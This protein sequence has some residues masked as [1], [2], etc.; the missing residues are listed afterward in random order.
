MSFI[1]T[2]HGDIKPEN[3]GVVYSHEHIVCRPPYWVEKSEDDL[4]LDDYEASLKEVM[5]FKRLGGKSIVDATAVDYGRDVENVQH[6]AK[7]SGVNIL[8]TAG[9][10]KSFLWSALLPSRL[11]A[12]IGDYDT[13]ESWIESESVNS[14]TDFVVSEV[15]EGLEGTP[16]KAGQV[17]FGTGYNSITPLEIKTI[18]A[19]A[20]AHHKTGA[21][22]HSHTEAGTMALEQI[23]IL[24]EEGV[25][26]A[27]VSFGHMDRNLDPFYHSQIAKTGAFLSF[28]GI[29]KVKYASESERI[30][31]ILALIDAGYEE[32]I[33]I[34][35]DTARKSYFKHYGHGLGFSNI[36]GNWVPRFKDE[37][38]AKGYD[39]E[40]LIQKFFIDNPKRCFTFKR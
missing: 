28:D 35:G 27:N 14:L 30:R 2:L 32:Q 16:Y 10:N 3:M 39:T 25:D 19:V 38:G 21:P 7:I 11:K 33:L 24:E 29:S 22:I 40:K 6:I 9:F 20:R 31:C 5:D 4:I 18:K 23:S 1:R 15:E 34:S 13:Y 37:A 26:I 8:G 12:M 36:L 17:K